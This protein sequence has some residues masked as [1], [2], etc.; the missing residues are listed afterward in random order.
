[1]NTTVRLFG[2]LMVAAATMGI[3]APASAQDWNWR[4]RVAA[5]DWMEVKA[6][7]GT[8]RAMASSG[9]EIEVT[10]T[11]SARRSDPDEV[12][13]VV[14][15]HNGGVTICAVYPAPRNRED[16]TCEPGSRGRSNTQNNDVQVDFVVHVPRG[17]NF[18]GRS[19]NGGVTISGLSGDVKAHT[20]NGNVRATTTGTA[21]ATT[22]NGSINVSMG[23]AD[24]DDLLAFETVNGAIVIELPESVSAE[25]NASTV[26]GSISTDYSLPVR[27]RW[28]PKHLSGTI[29]RGGRELTLDTVNGSIE[30]RKRQ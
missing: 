18:A 7:N 5:G 21:E 17:T 25:V 14:L 15:E 30:I 6:V 2:G 20:V 22:V 9:N 12:K 13:I 10:A 16:N 11:K 1:M 28:G 19:V 3:T 4:G 23:R 26:N 29:G 27:G 24:W 8:V